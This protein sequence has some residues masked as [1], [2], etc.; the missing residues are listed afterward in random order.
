[1]CVYIVF[2]IC[3]PF[4]IHPAQT[5][6]STL[7]HKQHVIQGDN[8][9]LTMVPSVTRTASQFDAADWKCALTL[10]FYFDDGIHYS[11]LIL[12]VKISISDHG[13]VFGG[14]LGMDLSVA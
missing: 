13:I 10:Y 5:K 7:P 11:S 14:L 3:Y 1:M 6:S 4:I 8:Y 12:S 2:L 9:G